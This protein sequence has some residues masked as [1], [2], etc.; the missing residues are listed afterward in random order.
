M[1]LRVGA[2][3]CLFLG[4]SGLGCRKAL[5]P[6]T[7]NNAAP[8][9]WIT[10]AP[11]DTITVRDGGGA[12]TP[13]QIGRIPVRFH[14]YWA[15]SDQDGTVAGYYFAVVE[16]LAVPPEGLSTVPS[17]P[18][19][20]A[21]EYRFTTK[22]DSM[23]VFNAS[24][25]VPERQHAFFIYAVDNKGKP[26]PTPARFVFSAYDRFPPFAVID[27]FKAIGTVYELQPGGGV[28]PRIKTYFVTDSFDVTRIVPRDTV[29]RNAVLT[30][31]WHGVPAI[32]STVIT[33]YQIGRASCRERV[34][35]A[36]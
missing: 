27:E 22:T 11:Q 7:D 6:P 28:L 14:L 8:Q 36:V 21:R 20:K 34:C 35:Y 2:V 19:P 10:A 25:D 9:T 33:G 4:I 3:L 29:P 32:P 13:P 26:D 24:E 15:G 5:E 23:F 1:R 12:A 30:A 18:G 17:L 31:K 16:T